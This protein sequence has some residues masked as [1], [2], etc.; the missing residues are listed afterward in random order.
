M[1][2]DI[3]NDKNVEYLNNT[4][5]FNPP[6]NLNEFKLIKIYDGFIKLDDVILYKRVGFTNVYNV[7]V[8]ENE[9]LVL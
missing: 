1:F 4:C 6:V 7:T 8:L 5:V 3:I 2:V 9:Q